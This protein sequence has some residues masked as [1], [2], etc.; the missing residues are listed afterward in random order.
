[1]RFVFFIP[2]LRGGGAERVVLTLARRLMERGHRVRLVVCQNLVDYAVPEG[3][4]LEVL[5]PK[6]ER[7]SGSWFAR[8]RMAWRLRRKLRELD[9][10]ETPDHL[11]VASLPYAWEIVALAGDR[12]AVFHVHN[13]LSAPLRSLGRPGKAERR[14]R[15]FVDLFRGRRLI[16]VSKGVADDLVAEFRVDRQQISV[17]YNP[18]DIDAVR[19]AAA[20]AVEGLPDGKYLLFVGRNTAQK[21]VDVLLDAFAQAETDLR[22]VMLTTPDAALVKMIEERGLSERVVLPGFQKNPYAWMARA[23]ALVLSSDFEGFGNVLVEALICGCRVVSTDCASGP[24][25]ILTGPLADGLAPVADPK[26]LAE[27]IRRVLAKPVET[28]D[29]GLERF[30]VDAAADAFERL[31]SDLRK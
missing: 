6:G 27:A 13:T 21:R 5:L 31:A 11:F 26:A 15:R 22:L 18:F 16:A 28:D 29:H 2:D 17:V 12:R 3:I 10:T 8:L 7:L 24:S 23:Q 20:E 25:E 1:M 9:R 14:R 30:S 4:E 19:A